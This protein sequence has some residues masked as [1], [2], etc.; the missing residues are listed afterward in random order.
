MRP[1]QPIPGRERVHIGQADSI[2]AQS[3]RQIGYCEAGI[4]ATPSIAPTVTM[5]CSHSCGRE[6]KKKSLRFVRVVETPMHITEQL[7]TYIYFK[8]LHRAQQACADP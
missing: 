1:R 6:N 2:V 7:Y 5:Q 3:G 4:I 8:P